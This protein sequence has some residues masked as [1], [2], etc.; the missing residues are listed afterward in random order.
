[1]ISRALLR[2]ERGRAR[3]VLRL[4]YELAARLL[5]LVVAPRA[6]AYVART[7]A[8]HDAAYGLSDIDLV[9]VTGDPERARQRR[10]RLPRL[11]RLLAP[12]IAVYT[13]A[14]LA[15]ARS[16]TT[17][18]TAEPLYLVERWAHDELGLRE[19]PGLGVPAAEWRRLRG[20]ER[21]GPATPGDLRAAAW[22]ELQF[23]WQQT[24]RLAR[25]PGGRHATYLCFKLVAEP[26]RILLALEHGE[27]ERDR[28]RVLRRA[29]EA[30]AGGGAGAPAGAGPPRPPHRAAALGRRP[31]G[32]RAAVRADR[33]AGVR[34]AARHRV[35][36]T[37]TEP[38]LL[39][40]R[41]LVL[42]GARDDRFRVGDGDPR[43]RPD[44]AALAASRTYTVLR[45]GEL[46]VLG[47]DGPVD[48]LPPAGR[49]L[50]RQ[51]PGA[52]RPAR[53]ER[54]RGVP[55]AAGIS[56]AQDVAPAG[57]GGERR[58]RR[59]RCSG[60]L[61]ARRARRRAWTSPS[62]RRDG[63]RRPRAPSCSGAASR[64]ATR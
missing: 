9:V 22:L 25:E 32:L 20:R 27:L 60:P 61:V 13:P 62:A 47:A 45:H 6:T 37:G 26:A 55:V 8:A 23:W 36:L 34:R 38:V 21:R 57:G 50:P 39:D 7:V 56:R 10:E 17:L 3:P 31:D 28:E 63:G 19:R 1:M 44:L 51:R 18:T 11:A 42:P 53:R 4:A 30:D 59:P 14:E 49:A 12:E 52:V 33:A 2:L 5:A 35:R 54:R 58:G 64:T 16:A 29:L 43:R 41:G 46:A 48:A 40:W 24:L 15:A